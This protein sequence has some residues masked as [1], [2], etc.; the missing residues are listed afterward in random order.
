MKYE[1]VIDL[2][3]KIAA[4]LSHVYFILPYKTGLYVDGQCKLTNKRVTRFIQHS[5]AVLEFMNMSGLWVAFNASVCASHY[6][7][8]IRITSASFR[9]ARS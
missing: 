3:V 5:G 6:T 9:G 1:K 4:R 8:P 7:Q 2:Q